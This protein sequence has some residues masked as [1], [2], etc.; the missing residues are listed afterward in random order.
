MSHDSPAGKGAITDSQGRRISRDVAGELE[1]AQCRVQSAVVAD[2][3]WR[4]LFTE[5][6][7][8]RLG[9]DLQACWS[10]LGTIHMWMQARKVAVEQAVIDVA[11]GLGMM[12][13][14]T[15]DFLRKELDLESAD[16]TPPSD[17]PIWR[18]DTG[19]L[20]FDGRV[21]RRIRVMREP[22]NIQLLLDAFEAAGWP[23]RI[24]NILPEG[25]E[26]LHQTLRSLRRSLEKIRF[27]SQEGGAAILWERL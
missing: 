1:I 20:W 7:R 19:E 25:Q 13:K 11:H 9:G 24:D 10:G 14:E 16:A 12:S 15:V 23:A 21:I 18:E 26:Q 4:H 2:R 22:S 17:R 5:E 3:M 8:Q 27:R 6:D